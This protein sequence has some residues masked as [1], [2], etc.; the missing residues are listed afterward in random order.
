MR[1][2]RHRSL[3]LFT[4]LACVVAALLTGR[5]LHAPEPGALLGEPGHG[6]VTQAPAAPPRT[7]SSPSRVPQHVSLASPRDLSVDETRGGHTL[8]RHV[9]LTESDLRE[10]LRREPHVSAASTYDD[11]RTAEW[12]VGEALARSGSRLDAWRARTG[13]RPN[14]VIDYH[15]S[16][17]H[18]IGRSLGRDDGSVRPCSDAIVVLK[19]DERA[20]DFFVLTSYPECRQ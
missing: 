20:G 3:V 1:T 12:V 6:G 5:S 13:R 14:L 17:A 19:W 4:A 18:P 11:V 7:P 8:K 2:A 9:G 15:G 10:R 16:A